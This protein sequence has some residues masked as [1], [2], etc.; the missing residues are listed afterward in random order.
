MK[1][2]ALFCDGSS[3]GNPGSGGWAA[4]LRYANKTK[5]ISG[6]FSNVTN[7]QMEL[8]AVI[9]GLK[10]LREPCDVDIYSDSS[11]VVNAIN[12]WLKNWVKKEFKDVKNP[13]LWREYLRVAKLHNIKAFW[14]KGHNGHIENERCDLLA[15][16]EAMKIQKGI[17]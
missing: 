10:A 6:G 11:Y 13:D 12:E 3:L 8:R 7:N 17:K 16:T 4:I 5:E 14:I 2:V 15:K 9:E 1:R